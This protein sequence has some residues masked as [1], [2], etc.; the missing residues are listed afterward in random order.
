VIY[1]HKYTK[2]FQKKVVI[3]DKLECQILID[4]IVKPLNVEYAV[5]DIGDNKIKHPLL[6]KVVKFS[7]LVYVIFYLKFHRTHCVISF[8]DNGDI[9]RL[10]KILKSIEFYA[11]Q[12][13]NR[14]KRE[15][16]SSYRYG[17]NRKFNFTNYFSF[18]YYEKYLFEKYGHTIKKCIPVGSLRASV[19]KAEAEAEAGKDK[20]I[21]YD[22]CFVSMWRCVSFDT[23]NKVLLYE[24]EQMKK[25]DNF[26]NRYIESSKKNICICM[27]ASSENG[28]T[29]EY[30]YY[31]DLFGSKVKIISRDNY[32]TYDAMNRSKLI[33]SSHSTCTSESF[34]WGKKALYV[35]FSSEN[36]FSY[37]D[38]RVLLLKRPS[39]VEFENRVSSILN[40]NDQKYSMISSSYSNFIMKYD[41]CIPTYVKIQNEIKRCLND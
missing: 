16:I 25:V 7:F 35:D 4:Y 13:G 3:F 34:G 19:Y 1:L 17:A 23:K 26:L 32:S 5:V 40:M 29:A 41:E 18:G 39:Y 8:R 6:Q 31:R 30:R 12:N 9:Q 38:E 14:T 33:I 20:S 11:I 21:I 36:I 10:S 2:L 15:L 37:F 22:I 27:R 24:A 28:E